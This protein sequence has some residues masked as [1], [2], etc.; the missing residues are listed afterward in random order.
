MGA[1]R[2]VGIERLGQQLFPVVGF[3]QSW[4]W[5]AAIYRL[6]LGARSGFRHRYPEFGNGRLGVDSFSQDGAGTGRWPAICEK[7]ARKEA[8]T[9]YH[10]WRSSS[11][12]RSSI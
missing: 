8:A 6:R 3:A 9:R 7:L 12:N 11:A 2:V 10:A 1:A 4:I 5:G